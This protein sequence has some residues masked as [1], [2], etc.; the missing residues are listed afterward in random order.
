LAYTKKVYGIPE[1][2]SFD[3][4]IPSNREFS[5]EEDDGLFYLVGV[6]E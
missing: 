6:D 5:F 4:N 2:P 3:K 1:N